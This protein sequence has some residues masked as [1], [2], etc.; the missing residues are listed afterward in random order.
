MWQHCCDTVRQQESLN[1]EIILKRNSSL[2]TDR[3][4][5]HYND[6][7]SDTSRL[8]NVCVDPRGKLK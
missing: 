7:V 4:P 1:L 6:K 8:E 5:I 3:Q 2:R